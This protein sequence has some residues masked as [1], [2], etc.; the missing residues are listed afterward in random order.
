MT[1]RCNK[2]TRK[3]IMEG[4]ELIEPCGFPYCKLKPAQKN[5]ALV[6]NQCSLDIFSLRHACYQYHT[7]VMQ[8]CFQLKCAELLQLC[9][10]CVRLICWQF[11]QQYNVNEA[12][13]A[14]H[15]CCLLGLVTQSRQPCFSITTLQ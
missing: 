10:N 13:L 12:T 6:H 11:C 8:L 4:S 3:A 2:G 7:T 14:C 15:I 9:Y 5:E 1:Q